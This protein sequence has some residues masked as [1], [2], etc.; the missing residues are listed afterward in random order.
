VP[1][2]PRFPNCPDARQ[3]GLR[4]KWRDSKA[5]GLLDSFDESVPSEAGA[6][7]MSSGHG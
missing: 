1:L 7:R 4:M 5:V 3:T 2:S 6:G